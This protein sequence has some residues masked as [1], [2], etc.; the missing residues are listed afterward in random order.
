MLGD[1]ID[2]LIGSDADDAKEIAVVF[3]VDVG[4]REWVERE[5]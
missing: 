5:R 4:W 3:L 2:D 1:W